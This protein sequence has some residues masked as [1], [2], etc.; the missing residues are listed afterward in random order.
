MIV[1][2]VTSCLGPF[3][4]A[5]TQD[6]GAF[7]TGKRVTYLTALESG[8]PRLGNPIWFATSEGFLAESQNGGLPH[9]KSKR[10]VGMRG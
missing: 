10:G 3:V 4:V 2:I 6:R 5:V 7:Y 1:E 8:S 9:G